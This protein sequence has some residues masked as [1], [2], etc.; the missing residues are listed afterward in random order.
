MRLPHWNT[1]SLRSVFAPS[2]I[3]SRKPRDDVQEKQS[4]CLP[5]FVVAANIEDRR[6]ARQTTGWRDASLSNLLL[7]PFA[8][9]FAVYLLP[10]VLL[11]VRAP[12]SI[13]P[14]QFVAII[15]DDSSAPPSGVVT[16]S[17]YHCDSDTNSRDG[18][19]A[20]IF[21]NIVEATFEEDKIWA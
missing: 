14:S 3:S 11:H 10:G 18:N 5:S 20:L 15:A 1:W 4:H 16:A 8:S 9:L 7:H 19:A 12:M 2:S 17:V 21:A 13:S 6:S